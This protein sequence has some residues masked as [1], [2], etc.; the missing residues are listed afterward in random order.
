MHLLGEGVLGIAILLITLGR[1]YQLGGTAPRSEDK[2]ILDGPYKHVRHP[3]YAAALSISL[4]LAC[5]SQSWAC[6]GVFY[7]YFVLVLLLIPVEEE[8]LQ[9]AYG[10]PYAVYRRTVKRLV[11]LLY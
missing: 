1:N 11:P 10:E 7:V 4:G 5:L 9:R 2:I 3:M 6:F 8:G